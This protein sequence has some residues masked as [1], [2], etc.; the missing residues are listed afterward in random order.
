ML[1]ITPVPVG[2]PE[3]I[4]ISQAQL[5]FMI[6]IVMASTN[7]SFQLLFFSSFVQIQICQNNFKS[8]F[9][10][11][12]IRQRITP[13]HQLPFS[14]ETSCINSDMFA[15]CQ[16]CYYLL[17]IFPIRNSRAAACTVQPSLCSRLRQHAIFPLESSSPQVQTEMK[18]NNN[19]GPSDGAL[20]LQF[21][22]HMRDS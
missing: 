19:S 20:Q 5:Y 22:C 17:E 6:N 21:I 18:N 14:H 10:Q 8:F 9:K 1:S 15:T 16:V 2:L 11:T 13:S 7:N 12:R 3:S 4:L